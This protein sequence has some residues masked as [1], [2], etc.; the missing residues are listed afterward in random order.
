MLEMTLEDFKRKALLKEAE[1]FFLATKHALH[2]SLAQSCTTSTIETSFSTL[3]RCIK[4]LVAVRKSPQWTLYVKC[5]YQKKWYLRRKR[6]WRKK[7]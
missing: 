3:R 5:M 4:N 6:S 1:T 2:I 7:Y